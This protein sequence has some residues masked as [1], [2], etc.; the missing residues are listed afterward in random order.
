MVDSIGNCDSLV[1]IRGAEKVVGLSR[2]D[3]SGRLTF[4]PLALAEDEAPEVS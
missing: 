2:L 3:A 1:V 4:E